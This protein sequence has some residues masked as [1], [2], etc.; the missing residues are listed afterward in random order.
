MLE[1]AG[2]RLG[3]IDLFEMNEAFARRCWR[4]KELQMDEARLNVNGGAT[5]WASDR[6]QR[7]GVSDAAVCDGGG[8]CGVGLARYAWR[9]QRGDGCGTV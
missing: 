8:G 9:R 7:R 4:G 2:L 3:D 1:K 6:G 5:C